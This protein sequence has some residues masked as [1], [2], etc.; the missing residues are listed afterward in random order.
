MDKLLTLR[1]ANR[2]RQAVE[3]PNPL[4]V[5]SITKRG[6]VRLLYKI[7]GNATKGLFRDNA[8]QAVHKIFK[9]F[10]D[11]DIDYVLV[12]TV[13]TQDQRGA[14]NAKIWKFEIPFLNPNNRKQIIYGTITAAGAGSVEDPLSVYDLTVVLG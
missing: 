2:F 8:W 13:Y 11:R 3:M 9:L 7:I 14:P 12:D 5:E 4:L 10:S 6:A 1:V